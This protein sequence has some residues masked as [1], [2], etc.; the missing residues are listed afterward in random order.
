MATRISRVLGSYVGE[1]VSHKSTFVNTST[2]QWYSTSYL[3]KEKITLCIHV[4]FALPP[5][6]IMVLII[7]TNSTFVDSWIQVLQY[8]FWAS[9]L[10]LECDSYECS[11]CWEENFELSPWINSLRYQDFHLFHM[12]PSLMPRIVVFDMAC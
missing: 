5:F 1:I 10:G 9:M 11:I 7:K 6:W 12:Y 3:Q 8:E 4:K 2:I